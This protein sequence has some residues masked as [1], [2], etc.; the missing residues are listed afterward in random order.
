MSTNEAIRHLGVVGAGTMGAGIAQVAATAGIPVTLVDISAD[1]LERGLGRV[2]DSLDRRVRRGQID[3][4]EIAA[5]L[6][7]IGTSTTVDAFSECDAVIEAAPEQLDLKQELFHRLDAVCP[8]STLIA[9]NTSSLSVTEISAG[10]S[11]PERCLGM[12]F[13]NPPVLM[14]LVEVIP[15]VRTNPEIVARGVTLARALGKT[16]VE[17]RDTP[18]FIVN[19]VLRPF[20]LEALRLLDQGVADVPTIDR[21]V[22]VGGG[23]PM[24]PFELI[25]LVGLDVNFAVSQSVYQS[26]FQSPRFRPHIVQQ[27]M[28]RAGLLGR[29]T[30]RGFYA[31]EDGRPTTADA[32]S[33]EA[34]PI[35]QP[36]A[37][38]G[39]GALAE[40]FRRACSAAGLQQTHSPA[41][42]KLVIAAAIGPVEVRR[43]AIRKILEAASPI[44]EVAV[45]CGPY[46]ATELVSTL[47]IQAPVAGFNLV[48]DLE[49]ARIVEVARGWAG[50]ESA[51]EAAVALF[52][53]FGKETARVTDS[54]GGVLNRML[55][56][57]ANEGMIALHEGLATRAAIDTAVKLGANHPRGPL[58]W[59]EY[60]GLDA[61]YQTLRSLSAELGETYLPAV[62]LRRLVQSGAQAV[63]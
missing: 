10:A 25:D 8:P 44:A 1:L 32:P 59:A 19:R 49:S 63:G 12:H 51:A 2:R 6:E 3:A 38:G 47:K 26:F 34:R 31:Y 36:V 37:I 42:A 4:S 48:G 46:S 50:R 28:V 45:H 30:G 21:I 43:L 41:D 39:D 11:R 29:K 5:T 18:G 58:E 24:G 33:V 53:A 22:K 55:A 17:A 40:A 27:Q 9:S 62:R 7:R 61:V 14:A 52:Q 15:G 20:Y 56:T 16:P 23:F 54:P 35:P 57:I 13:F 60:L